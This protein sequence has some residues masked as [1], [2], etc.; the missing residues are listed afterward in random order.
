MVSRQGHHAG[1]QLA[2]PQGGDCVAS[3]AR[4]GRERER[5]RPDSA[6]H[7]LQ[8]VRRAAAQ[9][10]VG[11]IPPGLS[12]ISGSLPLSSCSGRWIAATAGANS[13]D[14]LR[15]W[16]RP[17]PAFPLTRQPQVLQRLLFGGAQEAHRFVREIVGS[18]ILPLH[19]ELQT[20][21]LALQSDIRRIRSCH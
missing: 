11:P 21:I 12:R 8:H 13:A 19:H 17:L 3:I 18:A 5:R 16:A 4:V 10:G 6:H 1:A 20:V 15:N 14:C 2:E 7:E 9:A